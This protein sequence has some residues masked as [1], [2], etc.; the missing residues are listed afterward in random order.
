MKQRIALVVL[1]AS[2]LAL[3][4][5]VPA[6]AAPSHLCETAVNN[7]LCVGAPNLAVDSPVLETASGRDLVLFPEGNNQFEIK[8]VADQSECVAGANNQTDVVLHHCNGGLGTFWIKHGEIT[9]F[10]YESRRFPGK[11]LAGRGTQGTQYQLKSDPTPGWN[12]AF[13]IS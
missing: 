2:A 12:L 8:L 7:T 11:Y 6:N 4:A 10:K 3:M 9:N 13:S 5:A 1:A